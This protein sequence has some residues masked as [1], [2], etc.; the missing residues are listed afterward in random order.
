[1][2]HFRLAALSTCDSRGNNVTWE[3]RKAGLWRRREALHRQHVSFTDETFTQE[4]REA[5][6]QIATTKPKAPG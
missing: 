1:M 4:D 2:T 3:S 6:P 5:E